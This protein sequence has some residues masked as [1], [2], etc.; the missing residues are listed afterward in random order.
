MFM[1]YGK[2]ARYFPFSH[3]PSILDSV[4]FCA[5]VRFFEREIFI[6]ITEISQYLSR[7]IKVYQYFSIFIKVSPRVETETETKRAMFMTVLSIAFPI[8][9]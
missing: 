1:G 6:P 3:F 2:W 4:T 9:V 7:F 8:M 5:F